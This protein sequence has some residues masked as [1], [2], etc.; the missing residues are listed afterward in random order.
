MHPKWLVAAIAFA[1]HQPGVRVLLGLR[2]QPGTRRLNAIVLAATV[3]AT[4]ATWL[5][6]SSEQRALLAL[7]VFVAGHFLWSS[8][9]AWLALF[10]FDAA[11]L[12]VHPAIR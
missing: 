12:P 8:V 2:Q 5:V 4:L 7:A 3:A 6:A 11:F 10:R 9:F 1:F